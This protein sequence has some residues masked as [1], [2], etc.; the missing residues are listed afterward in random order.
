MQNGPWKLPSDKT[1][2]VRRRG[3]KRLESHREG[4][5]ELLERSQTIIQLEFNLA[6]ILE[7]RRSTST[8]RSLKR[9]TWVTFVFLPLL[10]VASLFGM[11]V[12]ILS[13]DPSWWWYFPIAGGFI[14]LTFGVW[15]FFKRFHTLEGRL[16]RYFAWLVGDEAEVAYAKQSGGR[17]QERRVSE[18]KGFK[19][20]VSIKEKVRRRI[21]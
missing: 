9:L 16:E 17:R 14:L 6:S 13:D 19:N 4:I 3:I 10:F 15:I 18:E 12:D 2:E 1:S 20:F 11:N 7:A 5:R 8:N 21:K